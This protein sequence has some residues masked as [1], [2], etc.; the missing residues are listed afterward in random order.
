MFADLSAIMMLGKTQLIDGFPTAATNGRDEKYGNEFID[1]LVDDKYLGFVIAHENMH[2]GCRHLTIYKKLSEQNQSVANQAT[3]LWINNKLKKV[4]PHETLIKMPQMNGEQF[5]L[6]D[7]KYD[8]WSVIKIFKHLLANPQEQNGG[9]GPDPQGGE[10]EDG[11]G[12]GGGF[13]VHD[14]GEAKDMTKEEK[15]ALEED[16][17]QAI[18][19]GQMVAKQRAGQGGSDDPFELDELLQPVINWEDELRQFMNNSC[20]N[21]DKS[22][23]RRPNRRFL[24][25]DIIMPTLEGVSIREIVIAIDASGSMYGSPLHKVVSE[26]KGLAETLNITKVHVMYWDGEVA[27][28]HEEYD[29]QSFKNF[30]I[31]TKPCGGGGTTP[32]CVPA[33]MEEHGIQPECVVMLTD[34]E[35]YGDDWGTWNM[36]VMWAITHDS[37][38]AP[39]G[40]TIHIP[41]EDNY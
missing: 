9:Q 15:I 21:K 14:W 32:T 12:G 10:G 41:V 7:P 28:P 5:G 26:T 25:Q 3:D 17:K 13:D 38:T 31:D 30:G 27:T 20:A 16:I 29:I 18:R 6:Y 4:D 40:K 1:S 39:V 2:K 35:I 22:T 8:G 23:W 33:Y 34:G 37:I 36:P 24:H 11:E 19:Q